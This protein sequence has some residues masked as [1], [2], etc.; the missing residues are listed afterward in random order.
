MSKIEIRTAIETIATLLIVE[1]TCAIIVGMFVGMDW[2][3]AN[4]GVLSLFWAVLYLVIRYCV[5][6]LL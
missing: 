2:L 6:L 3:A 1:S 4:L 5:E